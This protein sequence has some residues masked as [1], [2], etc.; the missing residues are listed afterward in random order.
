MAF[1]F[2][3]LDALLNE[4]YDEVLWDGE[5]IPN[6]R[7]R[8][9]EFGFFNGEFGG[10]IEG[11][12]RDVRE[13]DN[14]LDHGYEGGFEFGD[15]NDELNEII[16]GNID[17]Q[18][19]NVLNGEN[20]LAM[21][22]Y[23]ARQIH[24][25]EDIVIQEGVAELNGEDVFD[26]QLLEAQEDAMLN[27]VLNSI[28]QGLRG[29][30]PNDLENDEESR[31]IVE[32]VEALEREMAMGVGEVLLEEPIPYID[33]VGNALND[34]NNSIENQMIME[35]LDELENGVE[36]IIARLERDGLFSELV[37]DDPIDILNG[38]INLAPA[39]YATEYAPDNSLSN[40]DLVMLPNGPDDN[41]ME[42]AIE[43]AAAVAVPDGEFNSAEYLNDS[44]ELNLL[45]V[46]YFFSS[47][48]FTDV[49]IKSVFK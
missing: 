14:V 32:A 29:N 48:I 43:N 23:G 46:S 38:M 30:R 33:H 16:Y 12:V 28:E 3:D 8:D 45:A 11:E 26:Q 22:N 41:E 49:K 47:F 42:W 5:L 19:V 36:F 7:D 6:E 20:D 15:F 10:V 18:N 35:A 24:V 37:I 17:D 4:R 1:N 2:V 27:N 13:I 9:F 25:I 44:H 31:L 21:G 34:L 39:D 40:S